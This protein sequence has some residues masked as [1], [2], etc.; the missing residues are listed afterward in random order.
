MNIFSRG[1]DVSSWQGNI[2]FNAVKDGGVDFVI[3][4]AGRGIGRIDENFYTNYTNAKKAGLDVGA[5]WYSYATDTDFCR[6]EAES[7]VNAVKGCK[8]E[9]PLYFDIEEQF[10]IEQGKDFCSSLIQTFCDYLE[11]H[12]YFSGFYSYLDMINRAMNDYVKNR[13]SCWVAQW[14]SSCDYK[15]PYA[16]WQHSATGRIDGI[17]TNVDCDYC[18]TDFPTLIKKLQLNGF[19]SDSNILKST[20]EIAQEVL[21]GKWNVGEERRKLLEAAGYNY[22]LVQDEVNRLCANHAKTYIV[23]TGDTIESILNK[24]NISIEKFVSLNYKLKA[25]D[26][27]RIEE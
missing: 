13:Y 10:Q 8:F 11:E 15:Y 17:Q 24:F 9:Y 27:I 12:G 26:T 6:Q 20:E 4:K 22:N 16:M 23:Q 18:Y 5:Y 2:D 1:I 3:I 19:S 21:A 25:G 7:F 14:N